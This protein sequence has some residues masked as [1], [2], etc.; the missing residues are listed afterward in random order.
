MLL[1]QTS[2]QFCDFSGDFLYLTDVLSTFSWQ[3]E[4]K[5][6][7]KYDLKD[8]NGSPMG[9]CSYYFYNI[10][11]IILIFFFET[12]PIPNENY[13]S[14]NIIKQAKQGKYGWVT[15]PKVVGSNSTPVEVFGLWLLDP[16][17]RNTYL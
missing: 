4:D 14:L 12:L 3:I 13:D 11:Y 9:I 16:T 8:F 6:T 17:W 15:N 2:Y 7:H 5:R 1:Q 10:F